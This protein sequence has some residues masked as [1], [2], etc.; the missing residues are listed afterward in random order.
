[1]NNYILISHQRLEVMIS[2][3][4]SFKNDIKVTF[5]ISIFDG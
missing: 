3:H 1:M 5:S 2:S 4:K